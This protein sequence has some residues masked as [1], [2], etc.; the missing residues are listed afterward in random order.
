LKLVGATGVS[1][2][3]IAGL[4]GIA[5]G[6]SSIPANTSGSIDSSDWDQFESYYK[7]QEYGGTNTNSVSPNKIAPPGNLSIPNPTGF[8]F[9]ACAQLPNGDKLCVSSFE[10]GTVEYYDCAGRELFTFGQDIAKESLSV[11]GDLTIEWTSSVWIGIDSD[12]CVWVGISSAGQEEC[13]K[14]SCPTNPTGTIADQKNVYTQIASDIVDAVASFEETDLV[15][16]TAAG[17]ATGAFAAG[18]YRIGIKQVY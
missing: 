13:S 16:T 8:P 10:E 3:A 12:R 17:V 4:P 18:G 14:V 1:G 2:S 15:A 5:A 6:S 9:D 11:T 7:Q